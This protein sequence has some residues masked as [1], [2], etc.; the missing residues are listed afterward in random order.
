MGQNID[1]KVK[2]DKKAL[3]MIFLKHFIQNFKKS[4]QSWSTI[5]DYHT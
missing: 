5:V 2:I 4:F 3:L 1:L